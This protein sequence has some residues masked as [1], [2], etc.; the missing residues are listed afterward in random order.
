MKNVLLYNFTKFSPLNISNHVLCMYSVVI[1]TEDD[2]DMEMQFF[3]YKNF[4]S[5]H[6]L[7]QKCIIDLKSCCAQHIL[8]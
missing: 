5:F 1:T 4:T 8:H 6:I 2:Q 7:Y 3:D